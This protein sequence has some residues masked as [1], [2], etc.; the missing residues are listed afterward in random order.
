MPICLNP[1]ALRKT[2]IVCNFGLSECNRAEGLKDTY[3]PVVQAV[4]LKA[5]TYYYFLRELMLYL[6]TVVGTM[7]KI[8]K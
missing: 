7:A 6:W 1:I 2:K 3:L 4:A 8:E 5:S